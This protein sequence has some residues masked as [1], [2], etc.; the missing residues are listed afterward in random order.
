MGYELHSMTGTK[1][2]KV[3]REI[4]KAI[5]VFG[6]TENHGPHLPYCTDYASAYEIGRRVCEQV[7]GTVLLPAMNYGMSLHHMDFYLTISLRPEVLA[8]V[9][10]DIFRSLITHGIK[11]ILVIIGHDGNIAPIEIASRE[12]KR[13]H[14]EVVIAVF[15][16]WWYTAGRHLPEGFFEVWDGLGHAG[17]GET[18][19]M[20]ALFPELV[21]FKA[22]KK[23]PTIVPNV[24]NTDVRVM[25][26]FRELTNTGADGAPSK[27]TA[28]KGKKMIDLFVDYL[29]SFL[30]KM[31]KID[32]DY[33]IKE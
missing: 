33:A 16:A 6:A 27:G 20:M 4:D 22:A 10:K 3:K 21:D 28:E 24:P 25:W 14:D 19:L 11:R 1:T 12:I 17:E 13:E 7:K 15:E 18:S 8:E 29:V 26:K 5:V 30:N 32:W 2:D 31:D 23:A 9:A